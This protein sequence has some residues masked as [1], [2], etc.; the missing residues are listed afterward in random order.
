MPKNFYTPTSCAPIS[1]AGRPSI[2]TG[3]RTA[4]IVDGLAR[5]AQVHKEQSS[6]TSMN[7]F[8]V[9]GTQLLDKFGRTSQ[10]YVDR[11]ASAGFGVLQ[12]YTVTAA[13]LLEDLVQRNMTYDYLNRP[14]SSEIWFAQNGTQGQWTTTENQYGWNQDLLGVVFNAC[15]INRAN[16]NKQIISTEVA[17]ASI[18]NF[19][20]KPINIE[21]NRKNIVG[22]VTNYGFSEFGTDSPLTLEEVKAMN[23]PFNVCLSGFVWKVANK[24]FAEALADASDPSS[25][26]YL[27]ISTSWEMGFKEYGIAVGNKNLK[28][29]EIIEGEEALEEYSKYLKHFGGPGVDAKKR[30]VYLNLMGEILPL[31]IG[32]TNNPAAE[33]EGVYVH[34]V[35]ANAEVKEQAEEKEN[36]E[37]S[38]AEKHT[39]E[40]DNQN[41]LKIIDENSSHA[42]KANVKENITQE[43][44]Q[45]KQIM[46]INKIGDITEEALKEVAAS[47]VRSFL[48]SEIA[49]HSTEWA[50]QKKNK[51]EALAAAEKAKADIETS[52]EEIK[53]NADKLQKE[54]DELKTAQAAREQSEAFQSRMNGLDEEFDLCDEDRT[55]IAEQI[56]ELDEAGFSKWQKA[57]EVF[58]KEKSKKYIAAK[59]AEK[60]EKEKANGKEKS[61]EVVASEVSAAAA[62][63]EEAA[64]AAVENLEAEAA[65][66][67]NAGQ[68]SEPSLRDKMKAAFS[69]ENV[70]VTA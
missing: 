50:E 5:A 22:I 15:V 57:F 24:D 46:K 34:T 18:E 55:V 7:N 69:K 27:S 65:A 61:K 44:S 16:K 3:V 60:A 35:S 43:T 39:E 8:I 36:A 25:D 29:A 54:L 33:V 17:L 38:E 12:H 41:N 2:T 40:E 10:V 26:K 37:T 49:R 11:T 9:S 19:R 31:G 63:T 30:P 32:F 56:K 14:L 48:E 66:I 6:G 62:A 58:A 53:A 64:A 67:P 23:D 28:E 4:T 51:E 47:D 52:L 13:A 42:A 68:T 1:L 21:H 20:F 45:K 70:K 59:K